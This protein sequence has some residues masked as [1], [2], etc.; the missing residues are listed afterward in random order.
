MHLIKLPLLKT[1]ELIHYLIWLPKSKPV[2]THTYITCHH[3]TT[4]IVL[5]LCLW[6]F[7]LL[8][9]PG[10]QIWYKLCNNTRS[11]N[12]VFNQRTRPIKRYLLC[13]SLCISSISISIEQVKAARFLN[14]VQTTSRSDFYFIWNIVIK[15]SRCEGRYPIQHVIFVKAHI[16]FM[17]L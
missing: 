12:Y 3:S 10:Y 2:S 14:T 11:K 15:E 1:H 16:E 8:T 17:C 7:Y 4:T 6:T 9:Y 13:L 5:L